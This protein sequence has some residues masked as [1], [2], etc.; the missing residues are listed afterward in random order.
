MQQRDSK[1]Y[2]S[3]N[4][5][6]KELTPLDFTPGKAAH[7]KSKEC[8]VVLYYA[9]W[10]GYCSKVKPD[11]EQL[12]KKALFTNILAFNCEKYSNHLSKIK[13]ELP[14]LVRGFPTIV[15][16]RNGIPSHQHPEGEREYSKLLKA[17][18]EF[19]REGK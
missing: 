4:K 16:Y 19:C 8:S 13:E 1:S 2:F 14:E 17:C 12:G 15:F 3:K 18:M 11:W 5:N 7:L 9:P 10:C 6:V